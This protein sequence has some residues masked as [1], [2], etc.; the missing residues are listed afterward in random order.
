M[1]SHKKAMLGVLSIYAAALSITVVYTTSHIN[2]TNWYDVHEQ[3]Y[4]QAGECDSEFQHL[5]PEQ[6]EVLE[7]CET[8][9]ECYALASGLGIS[10]Q[11]L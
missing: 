1:S 11:C 2:K 10:E 5:T 4:E 7:M 8:D 6:I 9:Q 3:A